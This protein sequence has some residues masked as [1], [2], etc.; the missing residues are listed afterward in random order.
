MI[1]NVGAPCATTNKH[2][3]HSASYL[4]LKKKRWSVQGAGR[5]N[6]SGS[7]ANTPIWTQS[8]KFVIYIVN[9]FMQ[10]PFIIH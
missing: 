4:I 9:I 2:V 1:Q 6:V 10:L 7:Q 5:G 3:Y 8:N